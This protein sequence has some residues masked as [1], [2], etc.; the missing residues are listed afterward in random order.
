MAAEFVLIVEDEEKMAVVLID[1]LKKEGFET[2]WLAHGNEVISFLKQHTPDLILLDIMLPGMDGLE[3]CKELRQFSNIPVIMITARGEIM[4]RVDGLKMG[5]DDY[6]CKPFSP[7][8]VVAR[9]NA[10][11]QRYHFQSSQMTKQKQKEIYLNSD[12]NQLVVKGNS[13]DLTP[14]E[15]SILSCL[16]SNPGAVFSRSKIVRN[17]QGYNF[18]GYNRTIDFHIKNLRKKIKKFF[19][20]KELIQSI[21][22]VGY[23]LVLPQK[24]SEGHLT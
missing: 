20:H 5:A 9:I 12:S 14:C 17:V 13:I 4:D 6:I 3:I 23:K 24:N 19:G 7:I 2:K 22:G 16:F 15:F 18:E 21:Y 8:E 1:Y 10:V 11:L